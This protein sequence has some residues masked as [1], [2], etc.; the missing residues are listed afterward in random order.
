MP[1]APLGNR[2]HESASP[3]LR[4]HADN[5]VQWQPWDDTALAAARDQDRPIL[6]SIGYSACH[7]CHVMAHESFEDPATADVMNTLF[8]NIK[9]DREERPDLDRV[10]QTAHQLLTRQTGGW[11]LTIFL[12]PHTLIP[13]FS[14]TYFP[15][16]PKHGLPALTDLLQR[17][18]EAWQER[19]DEL[20][21]QGEKVQDMF[22]SLNVPLQADARLPDAELLQQAR[23]ALAAA[24]DSSAGGFGDAPKFPMPAAVER[25][26]RHWARSRTG[27]QADREA[28]DMA[29]HTLTRMARGGLFDHL[30]GGFCRYAV[31]REWLVPHFEKMLYDN[32]ALLALYADA[33]AVSPDPLLERAVTAT[34]TWLQRE[35]QSPAGAFHAALAADSEGEEGRFY[36]WHREQ[37]RRLLDEDE[38]NLIATLYGIDKPPSFEGSWI[39][40]RRDAWRAVVERL[41]LERA[42]A[43]ALLERAQAKLFAAREQRPRPARDDKILVSWNGLTIEGLARAA[44]VMERPDWGELA[45]RAVDHLRDALFVDG[46]LHAS[47]TDGRLG[48]TGFLEDHAFLLAGLLRLLELRWRD[49]DVRLAV[50]L[51]DALLRDFQDQDNGG[52]FQTAHDAEALIYRPKPTLDETVPSG[53]GVAASALLRL[54]HLLGRSDYLEAAE[55]T[56]QWAGPLMARAPQAHAAL[57]NAL[58]EALEPPRLLIIRGEAAQQWRQQ[59]ASGYQPFRQI[60]AIPTRIDPESGAQPLLP[61]YLPADAPETTT[62][63]TC[64]NLSC[65]LPIT[66]LAALQ[67]ELGGSKVVQLRPRG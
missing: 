45:T 58:E 24:Y 37:I 57:C 48:A 47:L 35:M 40:H 49:A 18:S 27:A 62:A 66:S 64:S 28:L 21:E 23:D 9:V 44:V 33:M 53:N 36:I 38:Y 54:G 1:D 46:R 26:L 30:G 20:G 50:R 65:S 67:E 43:D 16:V 17:I 63:W 11:P 39:L 60:Y 61:D 7:W 6:L 4:Q 29:L 12:D 2:L 15:R 5:P 3:Y 59:V 51:A 10:Y 55:R 52:F 56:L 13:F 19:R 34:A 14:G 41:G 22:D 8:V 31:D 32:G 25:L 42:D